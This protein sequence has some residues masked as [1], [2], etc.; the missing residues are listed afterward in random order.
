VRGA[1]RFTIEDGVCSSYHVVYDSFNF[2]GDEASSVKD[3]AHNYCSM[4]EKMAS[5]K[6]QTSK[7]DMEKLYEDFASLFS[8]TL[9]CSF[10]PNNPE[11]GYDLKGAS[12]QDC[13]KTYTDKELKHFKH[14]QYGEDTRCLE[15]IADEA[16]GTGAIWL[17][18]GNTGKFTE[19]FKVRSAFRFTIE[20]GVCSSYHVVYDSFNI[21][22][23]E[24]SSVI[25]EGL[26]CQLLFHDRKVEQPETSR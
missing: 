24:A 11:V 26:G 12:I 20:D 13:F 17:D 19:K 21:L 10:D 1:F 23:D 5:Q 15:T 18:I 4:T 22:G 9:D 14:M 6:L 8:E 16:A 7:T 2:L 25:S 3:W